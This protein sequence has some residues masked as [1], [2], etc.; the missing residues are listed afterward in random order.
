MHETKRN[1]QYNPLEKYKINWFNIITNKKKCSFVQLDFND[2]YPSIIKHT[3]DKALNLAK[4]YL[5]I[6]NWIIHN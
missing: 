1:T 5:N 2:F 4:K 6:E 3:W